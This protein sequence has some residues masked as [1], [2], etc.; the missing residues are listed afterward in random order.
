MISIEVGK[1]RKNSFAPTQAQTMKKVTKKT[2][3]KYAVARKALRIK[4]Y[5]VA[6]RAATV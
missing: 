5:K 6:S 2:P 3:I 4:T 1:R